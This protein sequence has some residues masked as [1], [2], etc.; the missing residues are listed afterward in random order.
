MNARRG[1]EKLATFPYQ[2]LT[3]RDPSGY[4]VS[5]AVEAR[6]DA[7]GGMAE[8]RRPA[9][10]EIPAG[11]ELSLTGSHIRP[12]PG[13]GYD[14]RRHVT[15]W[16]AQGR[17]ADDTILL[18]ATDAW[19]WDEAEV[20]FFEYSERSVP[21]SRRYFTALSSRLGRAV[22]PQLSFFWLALRATRLPFLSA[23][24]VPVLLGIVI[25]A[26]EGAFDLTS[27]VLTVIGAAC[28]HLG[29][30]VANDVFDTLSG[31]DAANVNPTKYSG[32]SRVI[33]YGLVS[34]R[35]MALLSI[36]FY[37]IGAA[38]GLLLLA[39]RGSTALLVIGLLGIAISVFYT[40]PPFRLV[41]RG[42]GEIAVFLG[43]G[44]LMLLGAYVVQTR[45]EIAPGPA[46]ASIPIGILVALILYVNEVPDRRADAASG[47]RTLPTR[48][49]PETVL[50]VY[51]VSAGAAFVTVAA[52]V[53]L[54]FLPL[55]ALLVFLGVP[56]AL[57]VHAGRRR[58]YDSP[59]ELMP[60]MALNIQ[61]HLVVGG[62]LLLAYVATLVLALLA[63]GLRPFLG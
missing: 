41:Y 53:V 27:A 61:L 47:K 63:P 23:T 32:G 7:P 59:Y 57:R 14:Q 46:V 51:A 17:T 49:R 38:V 10:F 4:P 16:G 60:A 31:A 45:G 29:L 24:F 54:G 62:L 6:I 5:V 40:A 21:R 15:V 11:I 39:T 56:L 44:P 26:A 52:G 22:R 2:I 55:P 1:L 20:P 35:G 8:V 33:L 48:W 37:A 36:A 13:Y 28:V 34:L 19:G 25:A 42:L 18:R 3:W 58:S 50:R 30:N 43:F 12:T 9:G